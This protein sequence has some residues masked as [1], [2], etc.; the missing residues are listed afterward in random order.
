MKAIGYVGVILSERE[1]ERERERGIER[2]TERERERCCD[3]YWL[4]GC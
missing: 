3:G 1:R 4:C 2:N